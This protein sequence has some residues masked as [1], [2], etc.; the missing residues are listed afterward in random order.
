M[1][2]FKNTI[3]LPGE[4]QA[5]TQT[6]AQIQEALAKI[7]KNDIQGWE[8]QIEERARQ[9]P[10]IQR[11][12]NI[13]VGT[14]Y[15]RLVIS[16]REAGAGSE[17][18]VREIDTIEMQKRATTQARHIGTY[19]FDLLQETVS[20]MRHNR[21]AF[22][23]IR[24]IYEVAE[25][26]VSSSSLPEERNRVPL[27]DLHN[28]TG[29]DNFLAEASDVPLSPEIADQES[30][31]STENALSFLS[32]FDSPE[33]LSPTGNSSSGSLHSAD[34]GNEI[35]P[36]DPDIE[37]PSGLDKDTQMGRHPLKMVKAGIHGGIHWVWS[38]VKVSVGPTLKAG[39]NDMNSPELKTSFDI[40][41][42]SADPDLEYTKGFGTQ[43]KANLE[44]GKVF[45]SFEKG[46]TEGYPYLEAG[47]E[48]DPA[49]FSPVKTCVVNDRIYPLPR[50]GL[51]M[52][53]N[54]ELDLKSAT[55][56]GRM[57][58]I[59]RRIWHSA[60]LQLKGQLPFKSAIAS[61]LETLQPISQKSDKEELERHYTT[62]VK[63][64]HQSPENTTIAD[65]N[66]AQVM[67]TPQNHDN[68]N[69]I[70]LNQD[71]SDQNW[72]NVS[73]NCMDVY[74]NGSDV[75]EDFSNGSEAYSELMQLLGLV[76]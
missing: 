71:W 68:E 58:T 13:N 54:G 34:S 36:A 62:L 40:T 20:K 38:Q 60:Y 7:V 76:A 10:E 3:L 27:L 26:N 42:Q 29:P 53:T 11:E 25:A 49:A 44:V 15:Q 64:M 48:A 23:D 45:V 2:R 56:F 70:D 37:I 19:F 46:Q 16:R 50:L 43:L 74:T 1:A 30:D 28:Q 52:K 14:F 75:T 9:N 33:G 55:I 32:G 35:Q 31:A 51:G 69:C 67:A 47:I 21:Y 65:N 17:A 63:S 4:L 57:S 59:P 24:N 5:L 12:E 73:E 66:V 41:I 39:F 61:P 18:G 8:R 72:S 22:P 6:K